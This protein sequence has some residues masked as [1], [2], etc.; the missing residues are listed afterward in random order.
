MAGP[1]L[2]RPSARSIPVKAKKSCCTSRP[3]CKRCPVVLARL[4][5]EGL[6][7]RTGRSTYELSPELTKKA[8]KAARKARKR[9]PS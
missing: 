9:K 4:E 7:Q 2:H 6:A 1:Y 5:R 3:R 8:L